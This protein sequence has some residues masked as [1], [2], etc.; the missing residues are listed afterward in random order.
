MEAK[1]LVD[2][3]LPYYFSLWNN[4]DYIHV[5]DLNE[6]WTDQQ[7]W[8]YASKNNLTIITKDADFTFKA[9][10][11]KNFPRV[12]HIRVGNML[13]KDLYSTLHSSW[14]TI[15]S[16]SKNHRLVIVHPTQIEAIS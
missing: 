10:A 1:F 8:D 5:K 9:L 7:I 12:I 6:K 15:I 11:V 13:L 4:K 14:D 3:N 16:I 2:V